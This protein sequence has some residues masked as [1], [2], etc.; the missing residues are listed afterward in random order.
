MVTRY[1]PAGNALVPGMVPVLRETDTQAQAR[2]V[3]NATL[4]GEN[5]APVL[6]GI[7]LRGFFLAPDGTA[8]VDISAGQEGIVRGSAGE[9]FL[10]LYAMVNTLAVNFEEIRQVRFLVEGRESQTL[11]GHVDLGR[12]FTKR[13]DLVK[14]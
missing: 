11:A 5:R 7:S 9:E 6:S 2:E 10:A 4:S 13:L 8:Y 12:V 3:L 1:L 14:Q